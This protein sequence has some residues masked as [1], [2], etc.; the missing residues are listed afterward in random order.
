MRV[1]GIEIKGS[2]AILC[3]MTLK[4]GL[5]DLP[6]CRQTRLALS[7]DKDAESLQKFQF[8]LAK[9]I[10]DYKIEQVVIKERPQKGKFAGGAV[11]FK[12]EAAI[13]LI[14]NCPSLILSGNTIKEKIKQHPVP[15]DFKD[16]GLKGFQETAFIIAYAFLAK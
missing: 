7:N 10:E 6:E 14:S 9:L 12:I 13:Q 8:N 5:F 3:L 2:E 15:V 1:C 16:T 11:G 4:D